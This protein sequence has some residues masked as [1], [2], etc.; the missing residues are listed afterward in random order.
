MQFIVSNPFNPPLSVWGLLF[1]LVSYSHDQ[2]GQGAVQIQLLLPPDLTSR[3]GFGAAI[4]F[5]SQFAAMGAPFDAKSR[6][7]NSGSVYM[8][9]RSGNYW[10]PHS[11]LYASDAQSNDYFGRDIYLE[12]DYLFV[13]TSGDDGRE[14]R[15]GSV[16]VFQYDGQNWV[17]K[18]RLIASDGNTNDL[19]GQRIS[20]HGPY[21]IISSQGKDDHG[22][23]SG[24]AYIFHRQGGQWIEQAKLTA[25]DAQKGDIFGNA[26]A[27][28]DN[29]AFV[30]AYYEEAFGYHSGAV[31]VFKRDG[32]QW[33]EQQKLTNIDGLHSMLFGGSI[34]VDNDLA[35]IGAVGEST[36]GRSAGAVYTY[37][38]VN[39]QWVPQQKLIA[40]DADE[41]DHFGGA[42]HLSGNDAIVGSKGDDDWGEESGSAYLFHYDGAQWS[43]KTKLIASEGGQQDTFG[44]KVYTSAD[45]AMVS[46][47]Y[48]N[49]V[50]RRHA[51]AVYHFSLTEV[52]PTGECDYLKDRF[53]LGPSDTV[54]CDQNTIT[55]QAR[56]PLASYR[57]STGSTAPSIEVFNSGTY[58]VEVR[59]GNCVVSDTIGVFLAQG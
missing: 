27:I 29:Y 32:N 33:V 44:S 12:E 23:Y 35:L 46:A 8:Y 7:V 50:G 20:I 24:A 19:F 22:S 54:V 18:D 31:Y 28:T 15:S 52:P 45:Y 55:L 57:W 17:E 16:Y 1:M 5:S 38:L 47:G 43:E 13:G 30:G 4:G 14:D 49:S 48:V 39:E 51:G 37:Q 10:V 9:I 6:T 36:R 26:V 25:S 2:F 11:K 53:D 58:W 3:S 21:A 34:S 40:S 56:V 41:L 42:V 59:Q